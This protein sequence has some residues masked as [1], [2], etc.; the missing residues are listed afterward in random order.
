MVPSDFKIQSI[1]ESDNRIEVLYTCPIGQAAGVLK[2]MSQNQ[3]SDYGYLDWKQS[4]AT[5]TNNGYDTLSLIYSKTALDHDGAN[6]NTADRKDYDTVFEPSIEYISKPLESAFKYRCIWNYDL[7]KAVKASE[8]M[9]ATPAV[10]ADV[11]DIKVT[12]AVGFPWMF[13]Q[14]QPSPSKYK[15]GDSEDDKE[16]L[17]NW[18]LVKQRTKPGQESYYY[19]RPIIREKIY[20]RSEKKAT[21]NLA[22]AG[23]IKAPKHT[24]G[25]VGE[26][27]C[28]PDGIRKEGKYYVT[29]NVYKFADEWDKDLYNKET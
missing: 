5:K 18:V 3:N 10:P 26:W 15:E 7:Y 6:T 28:M 14:T 12:H 9:G 25:Y 23:K 29:V 16:E 19:P 11:N 21:D 4:K 17:Y 27:L 8:A 22:S 1:S 13:S 2:G 24:F 20:F